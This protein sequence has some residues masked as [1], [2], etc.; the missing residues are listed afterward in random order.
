MNY[1]ASFPAHLDEL[2]G[3]KWML[4]YPNSANLLLK[5]S[6]NAGNIWWRVSLTHHLRLL[7]AV[8]IYP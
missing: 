3:A 5:W 8:S 4:R 1:E 7:A 2:M 6:W